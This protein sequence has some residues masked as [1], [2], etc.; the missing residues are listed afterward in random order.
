MKFSVLITV[1]M[2]LCQQLPHWDQ[3]THHKWY[4]SC[5][6][7]CCSGGSVPKFGGNDPD[8]VIGVILAWVWILQILIESLNYTLGAW[9]F[10]N[11]GLY[12]S[13]RVGWR[14]QSSCIMGNVGPS[15]FWARKSL[16]VRI[17][18]LPVHRFWSFFF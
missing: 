12:Q 13:G 1:Y 18:P 11:L 4:Y 16:K 8:D 7:F 10:K 3:F 9:Y 17:P 6:I 5:I 14:M 15:I 2:M